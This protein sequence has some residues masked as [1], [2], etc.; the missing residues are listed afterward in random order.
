MNENGMSTIGILNDGAERLG[1]ALSAFAQRRALVMIAAVV[2]LNLA[3]KSWNLGAE[4]LWCDEGLSAQF[5]QMGVK[6]ILPAHRTDSTPPLYACLL[7]GWNVLF[8]NSETGLRSF[9]VVCSLLTAA[10]LYVFAARHLNIRSALFVSLLFAFSDIQLYYAREMR[11]YALTG[12]LCA[13]SV[14]LF[15]ELVKAPDLRRASALGVVNALIIQSHYMALFFLAAE[16]IAALV[17]YGAFRKGVKYYLL[18]Q[19]AAAALAAPWFLY[20]KGGG[21][22]AVGDISWLSRP[23]LSD[24]VD[25]LADFANG[26]FLLAVSAVLILAAGK[27]LAG[28]K[29]AW[30]PDVRL[31]LVFLPLLAFFPVVAAFAASFVQPVF[32]VRYV[33]YASQ[34]FLLL[35]AFLLSLAPWKASLKLAM[36]GFIV[37]VSCFR[38]DLTPNKGEDWLR[39]VA[40]VKAM[41]DDR[42]LTVVSASYLYPCFSYYYNR[43]YFSDYARTVDRMKAEKVYCINDASGLKGINFRGPGRIFLLQGHQSAADPGNTLYSALNDRFRLKHGADFSRLKLWVFDRGSEPAQ[44]TERAAP[45]PNDIGTG[46]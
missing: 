38:L 4:S 20:I 22:P 31:N 16:F 34:G 3:L 29:W 12:L 21:Y 28:G 27:S 40:Y 10:V 36:A 42:D 25:V 18:S 41:K 8:G 45:H 39:A 44:R 33:L 23:A 43:A 30:A 24:V 17:C 5:A 1:R 7:S 6:E 19:V 46:I 35:I 13:V 15:Y 32:N 9:S 26:K 37:V 2:L 11:T 14:L